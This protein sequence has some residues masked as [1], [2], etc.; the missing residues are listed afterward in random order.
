MYDEYVPH[1]QARNIGQPAKRE[2]T[3]VGMTLSNMAER[4]MLLIDTDTFPR[5][6]NVDE[7]SEGSVRSFFSAHSCCV[8]RD[9]AFHIGDAFRRL[10]YSRNDQYP[11]GSALMFSMDLLTELRRGKVFHV[12]KEPPESSFTI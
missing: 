6:T 9:I 3:P 8:T 4:H 1:V 7:L 10:K 5:V 2:K 12:T 11:R